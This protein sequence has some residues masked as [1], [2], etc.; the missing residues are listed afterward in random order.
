MK[1]I[2]AHPP[3]T[4]ATRGAMNNSHSVAVCFQNGDKLIS[5]A[6]DDS[7]GR[8]EKLG[9][10]SI[11]L[12]RMP[13]DDD[14]TGVVCTHEVFPELTK[15]IVPASMENFDRAMTWLNRVSWGFDGQGKRQARK[16]EYQGSTVYK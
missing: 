11:E 6:L 16:N 14:D 7:C 12:F 1:R 2:F 4:I 8:M 5:I 15:C 3:M 9:R 13:D 10:G